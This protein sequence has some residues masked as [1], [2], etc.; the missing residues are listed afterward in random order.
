MMEHACFSVI[1]TLAIVCTPLHST[2]PQASTN[3]AKTKRFAQ[4]LESIKQNP[5]LGINEV[6]RLLRENIRQ[7]ENALEEP[8]TFANA[9]REAWIKAAISKTPIRRGWSGEEDMRNIENAFKKQAQDEAA[10]RTKLI[11]KLKKIRSKLATIFSSIAAAT[12]RP[13]NKGQRP[14]SAEQEQELEYLR[15]AANIPE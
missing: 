9:N 5:Q 12:T 1:L 3:K 6:R 4:L 10:A 13:L 2:A 8:L 7:T 11:Q 15:A 14:L